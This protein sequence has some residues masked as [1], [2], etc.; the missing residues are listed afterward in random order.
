MFDNAARAIVRDSA[1]AIRLHGLAVVER[2]YELLFRDPAIE[3]IFDPSH[4]RDGTQP[5]A[6]AEAVIAYAEHIDDLET[7]LPMVERVAH[8]HVALGITAE[9]YG[10]VGACIIEA[11]GDVL[12]E[13]ATPALLGAWTAAFGVLAD[14]FI[15]RESAL[16]DAVA[17]HDGGWRG[18]R[19]FRVDRVEDESALIRSLYL[20]PVDGG[21][22]IPHVPGQ[23]LTLHLPLSSGRPLFRHYSLSAA[24]GT[25][26]YRIS[27]KRE[28]LGAGSGYLHTL[29]V[30][31][32]I[33]CAA[34]AGHFTLA[35][36]PERPVL[37][38][39]GGVGQ[40][41]ILSMAHAL[42]DRARAPVRYLHAAIDGAAHAFGPEVADIVARAPWVERHTCYER[43][44]AEDRPGID[45]DAVG[46]IDAATLAAACSGDPDVYLCGPTPFMRAMLDGLAAIG[47]PA[48]NVH[49]EFFGPQSSLDENPRPPVIPDRESF[50]A[51]N[52]SAAAEPS[53]PTVVA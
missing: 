39:S 27:V 5:R 19:D 53:R 52:G 26:G 6:L 9:H 44:R 8:K 2:M 16:A 25:T 46:R 12:G 3:L 36:A 1:P 10:S 28:P 43:P 30:G 51:V 37:L 15:N 14:I 22:V 33:D 31:T 47:V 29:A 49:F 23:Y 32:V 18:L 17:Y 38:L 34:P 42:A 50:I 41:P 11:M 13:A 21:T 45:Y 24:P 20:V 4:M 7:L 35:S 40:T 48:A